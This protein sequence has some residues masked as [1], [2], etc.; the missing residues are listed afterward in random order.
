[1]N[2]CLKKRFLIFLS[3]QLKSLVS[4]QNYT[5]TVSCTAV[6]FKQSVV[7]HTLAKKN[8][9]FIQTDKAVY[10]PADKLQFRILVLSAVAKPYQY[11]NLHV[12]IKDPQGK[13]TDLGSFGAPDLV[14]ELSFEIPVDPLLG[15]WTISARVDDDTKGTEK[16]FEVRE[17]ALPRFEPFADTR[18]H[19]TAGD[20]EIQLSV[21]A[22]YNFGTYVKGKASIL[23]RACDPENP[24]SLITPE[25]P[26]VINDVWQPQKVKISVKND[27]RLRNIFKTIQINVTITFEEELTRKTEI[28]EFPIMM[29]RHGDYKIEIIP[30]QPKFKPGFPFAIKISV[31][32]HDGTL[33]ARSATVS[34]KVKYF[35]EIA[36]CTTDK[37]KQEFESERTMLFSRVASTGIIDL[38]IKIPS[39][40]S[41]I[42][43][44]AEYFKTTEELTIKRIFT[45]SREY[46]NLSLLTP[47]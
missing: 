39:S 28:K 22:K 10:K 21:Y 32:N 41:S 25:Y 1:M 24:N 3:Q 40:T 46:I 37:E 2:K 13:E 19:L 11:K 20:G 38:D 33:E 47:R 45:Q 34:I 4:L 14:R 23:F 44:T 36:R 15:D 18:L 17:Y 12:T 35:F 30:S 5:L 31:K 9:V 26:R 8:S 6:N 16:K 42:K 43:V 7:I 29:R 27:L